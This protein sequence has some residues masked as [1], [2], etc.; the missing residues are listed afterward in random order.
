MAARS[1]LNDCQ[2]IHRRQH[3]IDDDKFEFLADRHEKPLAAVM[4]A[5]DIVTFFLKPLDEESG[6]LNIVFDYQN[7]QSPLPKIGEHLANP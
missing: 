3:P 2:P 4:H 6:G 7:A 1:A 5:A